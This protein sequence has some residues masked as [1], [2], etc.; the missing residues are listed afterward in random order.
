MEVR[1]GVG[2]EGSVKAIGRGVGGWGDTSHGE[3]RR[4]VNTARAYFPSRLSNISE[5]RALLL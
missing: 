4:H 5:L 2:W 1:G 3:R